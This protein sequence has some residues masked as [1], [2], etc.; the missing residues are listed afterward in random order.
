M[1]IIFSVVIVNAFF[2][3]MYD[4]KS[5][6]DVTI[7]SEYES[8]MG[9]INKTLTD[10]QGHTNTFEEKA[11]AITEPTAVSIF[12]IPGVILEALKIPF[13]YVK[14]FWTITTE[15]TK[16]LKIPTY[17]FVGLEMAFIILIAFLIFEAFLRYKGI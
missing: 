7:G 13:E 8:S 6:Y 17:V 1:I 16:V 15:F 11:R 9:E 2:F 12:F 14:N 10:M 4:G 5:K 3:W